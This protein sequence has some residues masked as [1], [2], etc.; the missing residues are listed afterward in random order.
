MPLPHLPSRR[1]P[2][3]RLA[4][5]AAPAGAGNGRRPPSS[6]SPPPPPQQRVRQ[7][8]D[9]RRV[10]AEQHLEGGAVSLPDPLDPELLVRRRAAH[11]R[12]LLPTRLQQAG[13]ALRRKCVA[14]FWEDFTT[15]TR[16]ARRG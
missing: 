14:T 4:A 10:A 15:E 11:P 16:R 9:A 13:R 3:G 12:T 5:P 6:R 8:E 1:A 7:P 2:S